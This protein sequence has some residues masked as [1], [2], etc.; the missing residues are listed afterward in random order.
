MRSSR[1]A[2][3]LV[4]RGGAP[5]STL[6]RKLIRFYGVLRL[7]FTVLNLEETLPP[8][9]RRATMA[10]TAMRARRRP[11]ST[12]L[13]PRSSVILSLAWIQVFRTKR[14]I[15]FS[16]RPRAT[17]ALLSPRNCAERTTGIGLERARL[18]TPTD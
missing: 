1:D 17:R 8:R 12:M 2:S 6:E 3:M 15:V 10:M 7:A 5:A 16:D 18:H 11:Y 13:A 4:P 14:A 9:V